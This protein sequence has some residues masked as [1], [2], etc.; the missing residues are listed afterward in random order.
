M[1][2]FNVW[3]SRE[4]QSGVGLPDHGVALFRTL[5][6][7]RSWSFI[8]ILTILHFPN[9]AGLLGGSAGKEST[10]KEGD[11]GLIPGL[12]RSPGKGNGHPLPYSG[13]ENSM[14]CIGHEVAK[15]WTWP[16][17]FHFTFTFSTVQESCVFSDISSAGI[18]WKFFKDVHSHWS[19][20]SIVVIFICF[21]PILIWSICSS[22]FSL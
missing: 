2:F 13:L 16:S 19:K 5:C 11:L 15:S 9:S 14:D 10:C 6:G 20:V 1:C 18:F 21:S 7:P 17:D 4:T 22:P 3:F 8:L 12:G